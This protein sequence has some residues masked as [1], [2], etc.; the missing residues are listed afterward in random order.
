MFKFQCQQQIYE[1]GNLKFGGQPGQLPTVMIGS[2]FYYGDKIVSDSKKGLFNKE[3]ALNILRNEEQE[4]KK[5]GN[6]R[7]IDINGSHIEALIKYITFIAENTESPFIIDAPKAEIRIKALK[8]IED[9][10][11]KERAVYNSITEDFR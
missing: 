6:K 1:I 4:S 3:L 7:I 11:L 2:I 9:V 8:H 5:T 10:G